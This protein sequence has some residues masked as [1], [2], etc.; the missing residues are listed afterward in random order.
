ME[1]LEVSWG[2]NIYLKLMTGGISLKQMAGK[3]INGT[4]LTGKAYPRKLWEPFQG[5][6]YLNKD[7]DK[8]LTSYLTL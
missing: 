1:C 7:L 6:R 2:I 3:F 5:G 4:N 8:Y